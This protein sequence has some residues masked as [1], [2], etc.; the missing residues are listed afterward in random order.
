MDPHFEAFAADLQAQ[1]Y[2]EVLLR[3]WSPREVVNTHSIP[4]PQRRGW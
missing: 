1:G 3:T 4:S 2:D